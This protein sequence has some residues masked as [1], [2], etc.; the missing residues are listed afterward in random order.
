VMLSRRALLSTA[1]R[2]R[3]PRSAPSL[4]SFPGLISRV[5]VPKDY[6]ASPGDDVVALAHG[7]ELCLPACHDLFCG[8]PVL[9]KRN[10]GRYDDLKAVA[11]DALQNR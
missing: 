7:P 9:D 4:G 6:R 10:D 5:S 1:G 2:A 3:V 11:V 8:K